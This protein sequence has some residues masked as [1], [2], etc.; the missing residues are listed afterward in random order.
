MKFAMNL[1]SV[2]CVTLGFK[3]TGEIDEAIDR[4]SRV[5]NT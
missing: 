5:M 2:D 4:M 1:G 3:N